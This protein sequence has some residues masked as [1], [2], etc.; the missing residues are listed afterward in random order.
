M[1]EL[2]A[3]VAVMGGG[4][5]FLVR[6]TRIEPNEWLRWV[7]FGLVCS[8]VLQLVFI[9]A[10][11]FARPSGDLSLLLVV[12]ALLEWACIGGLAKVV[13]VRLQGRHNGD[14]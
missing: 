6:W 5:A 14:R 13:T 3:V 12:S 1:V 7:L 9:L 2:S 10:R 4:L 8:G 11:L